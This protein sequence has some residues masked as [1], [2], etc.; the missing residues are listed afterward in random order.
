MASSLSITPEERKLL[1][2][3]SQRPSK[4]KYVKI[5]FSQYYQGVGSHVYSSCY[6]TIVGNVASGMCIS[7]IALTLYGTIQ[8]YGQINSSQDKLFVKAI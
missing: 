8:L 4:W 7:I 5:K 1:Y 2:Y 6:G 3:Y